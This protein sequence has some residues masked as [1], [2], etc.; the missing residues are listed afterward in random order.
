MYAPQKTIKEEV[1]LKKKVF[2]V[3]S[4]LTSGGSERVFWNLAQGF[5]KD[6][7]DVTIVILDSTVNCFSMDLEAVRFIDLKTKKASKSFFSLYS[8]LKKEAPYAVFSTTDHINILVSLVGRFLKIPMLIA[9][10]SN[11]PHEQRLFEGF[12]SRFYELFA[13]ASYRGYKQIVCQSEEM[14]QSLI[15]TYNVNQE[16]IKVIANPVLKTNKLKEVK[17]PDKVYRLLVVARFA[18]EKGLERLVDIMAHLPENYHLDFVGTG[19]LKEQI[20]AKIKKLQLD[21]RLKILGEIKNIHEVMVQHDLMVLSSYTEGFPN[22][23]LEALTVGLPVVTFRVSGIP[24]L[25]I[26]GFNGFVLEQDDL[27]GFRRRII[28]ACTQGQW[29]PAE[30]RRNVYQKCALDKISAQY[31][32]L[33]S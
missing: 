9:R 8:L 2:F 24:G 13:S 31:E 21:H 14:K 33:I 20:K 26:D 29:N 23:V 16:L 10:A 11:I 17:A 6:K 19:V 25:I 1:K 27:A 18:L 4:S 30:I 12:K 32:E 3:L 7:F 22:V 28:Q 5:N 15:D